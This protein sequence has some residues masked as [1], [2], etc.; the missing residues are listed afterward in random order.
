MILLLVFHFA[1]A[2]LQFELT[3]WTQITA[4]AKLRLH[5]LK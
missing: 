1:E 5:D 3:H 4:A 2:Q